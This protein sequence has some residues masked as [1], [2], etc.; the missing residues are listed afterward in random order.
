LKEVIFPR[1]GYPLVFISD[2]GT[3]FVNDKVKSLLKHH[4]IEHRLATPYH[5]QSNGQVEVTNRDLMRI[6]KKSIDRKASWYEHLDDALW[7]YRTSY[8]TR[9]GYISY[10]LIYGKNFVLPISALKEAYRTFNRLDMD[11]DGALKHR[12][13]ELEHLN[14][15]RL[16]AIERQSIAKAQTKAFHD[17]KIITKEFK[18]NDYILLYSMR[19][20][21]HP[22]KLKSLWEGPFKVL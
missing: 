13:M 3:Y 19:L 16:D 11:L 22:A 9:M 1:F 15:Y 12:A 2:N 4:D 8:K 18:I 17:S 7:A 21:K 5:P 20:H 10:Q 14:E 6:I